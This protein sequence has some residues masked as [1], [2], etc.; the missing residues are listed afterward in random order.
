[1]SDKVTYHGPPTSY[2]TVTT[3]FAHFHS[4]DS[5]MTITAAGHHGSNHVGQ[6]TDMIGGA[7]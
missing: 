6:Q 5:T 4:L 2:L 3:I 1:M 7:A